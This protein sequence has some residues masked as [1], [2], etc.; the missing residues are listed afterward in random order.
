MSQIE[1]I[2]DDSG[3][4]S[5]TSSGPS[6]T[7]ILQTL[8]RYAIPIILA[9]LAATIAYLLLS[10][11]YVLSRPM[12]RNTALGFRVEFPGAD[13]GLYPNGVRF[14]GSDIVDTPVLRAAYDANQLERY[15]SFTQFSNSV[16]VLEAN[17]SLNELAREY[18]AKLNNPRLTA[19]ERDRLESE[20]QQKRESLRKNEWAI[21]LTTREG[22]TRV[23]PSVASKTLADILRFWADF[24]SKTRQVLV[25]RVPLVSDRAIA[26][27]STFDND[28]LASFL[29][30]RLSAR[31][32]RENIDA[33]SRLPGA[34]V[35]RSQK[36]AASLRELELELGQLER[37]RIEYTINRI[38]SSG[39]IDR[40]RAIALIESQ[41]EYDRRTLSA[42]EERV[43]VLR[44]AL[45]DYARNSRT[46][47]PASAATPST[48]EQVVPQVSDTFLAQVVALA[49]NA[50]DSDFRQR[51]VQEIEGA[52]LITVPLRS[53][54][55]FEEQLLA[56]VRS[57]AGSGSV[58]TSEFLAERERVVGALGAVAQ[59]LIEIRG[60]LSRS[61]A[62]AGQIYTI[63][64]PAVAMTERSVSLSRLVLGF[65][66]L[67]G[68]VLVASIVAAFVHQRLTANRSHD[69]ATAA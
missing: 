14:S 50:S 49:Q 59:D 5:G 10:V 25:H 23:P 31:E 24:A 54:V 29:A 18:E 55:T 63:T 45:E 6:V 28:P 44:T 26:R 52:A 32:L 67:F 39:N 69:L 64:S 60:V 27:L 13:Q 47:R 8:R 16:V 12:Q 7:Y 48:G 9:L 19:V 4:A 61:L 53:A 1:Y 21:L 57:G 36:R 65:I 37:G 15:M 30:L 11:V 41:L 62:S 38:V 58:P 56:D 66:L 46:S 20:Y 34:E 3:S 35:V 42:A 68:M 33:L 43:S 51:Q 2:D 17:A 22:L 40:A